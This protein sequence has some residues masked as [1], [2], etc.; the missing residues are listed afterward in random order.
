MVDYPIGVP[1]EPAEPAGPF[2][3]IAE[4]QLLLHITDP[5]RDPEIALL[6][7]SATALILD[8]LKARGDATW[9][10]DTAP[11][12]VKAATGRALVFL[13]E[14]RGDHPKDTDT[15]KFWEDVRLLLDRRRDPAIA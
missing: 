8:Y 15:A 12:L 9:T 7:D 6:L 14:H 13:W 2:L 11:L 4:S 10:S 5:A 1:V 3:T